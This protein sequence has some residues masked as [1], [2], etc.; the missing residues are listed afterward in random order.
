MC[1][2]FHLQKKGIV[3][4]GGIDFTIGCIDPGQLAGPND[5]TRLS[6]RVEPV[7]LERNDKDFRPDP[8]EDLIERLSSRDIERVDCLRDIEI[9]VRGRTS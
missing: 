2:F 9:S 8:F 1:L 7:G 4:I 3:A 5:L 6:G